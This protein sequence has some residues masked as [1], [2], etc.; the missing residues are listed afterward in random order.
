[1]MGARSYCAT[2]VNGLAFATMEEAI[3]GDQMCPH[4]N[5]INRANATPAEVFE[6]YKDGV[7]S[8]FR[9]LEKAVQELEDAARSQRFNYGA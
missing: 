7:D 9:R 3:S 1:M 6:E 2:C 5:Y 8:R 4:C